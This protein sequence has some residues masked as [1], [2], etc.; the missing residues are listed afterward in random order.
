MRRKP[1]V[2]SSLSAAVW[3]TS[4]ANAQ[5]IE[6][7]K[8]KYPAFPGIPK[9][10]PIDL[11]DDPESLPS[12]EPVQGVPSQ[13]PRSV[14]Q[15]APAPQKGDKGDPGPPGPQGPA[16]PQGAPGIGADLCSNVPGVQSQPGWKK[17][18]QRYWSFRPKREKRVL[19]MN[20]R[21]QLVCVT[22]RWIRTHGILAKRTVIKL[23]R[24]R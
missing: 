3:F 17:W 23:G 16:G 13:K 15:S 22:Q 6:D 9:A 4:A 10:Q 5:T 8:A 19:S 11:G 2:I 7:W 18:P 24:L 20:S 12:D 1:L 21:G 14:S